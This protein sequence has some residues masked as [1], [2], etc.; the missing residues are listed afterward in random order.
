MSI[1]RT[2]VMDESAVRRALARMA[3]EVVERTDGTVDLAVMG[4]HR[5]GVD[6]A[7]LLR[8]EIERA[9]GVH[10]PEGSID[11]SLY[12]DDLEAIGPR[13]IL[14]GSELPPSGIHGKTIV[15]VDDVQFTGRTAR[16]A[17]NEL[18]AWG[19]P[20]RILLCVLVDRGG[21]ELPIQP[22]IVGRHIETL[23]EN[24]S[25][26]VLVPERDG[27]LGVDLVHTYPET[28]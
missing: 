23:E 13:P 18:M 1:E 24:V 5:R 11:I 10:V 3:R 2:A 6:I 22:D 9:E 8:E 4:I 17:M 21:R 19:R 26:E 25:V 14:G 7:A 16:A 15:L 20:A 12:R 28:V 27:R